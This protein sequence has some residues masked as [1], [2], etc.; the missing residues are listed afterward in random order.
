MDSVEGL[1]VGSLLTVERKGLLRLLVHQN[2]AESSG[3]EV[4]SWKRAARAKLLL[5]SGRNILYSTL[6]AKLP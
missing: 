3:F 6:H 4:E 5:F 2:P 1:P